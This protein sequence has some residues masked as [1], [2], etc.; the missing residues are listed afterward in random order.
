MGALVLTRKQQPVAY[1]AGQKQIVQLHK[2]MLYRELYL[3]L[4]GAPTLLAANNT[5]AKTKKGD[6]WACVQKIEIIVNSSDVIRSFSG[7]QLWQLNRMY[8]GCNPAVTPA[9]GDGA[10]A[11]PPF[12]ST[13]VIPFWSP[14][15][16]RPFD[17]AF[18]T[19]G[20]TDFRLEI[21]WG[22]PTDINADAAAFTTAPAIEIGSHEQDH[23]A[24]P[25]AHPRLLKR[26]VTQTLDVSGASG[27]FRFPLDVGPRY[28][29][30]L[31]NVTTAAGVDTAGLA[32]NFKLVSG[33][34][35]FVDVS[36]PMLYQANA[37]RSDIGFPQLPVV[38]TGIFS[39]APIRVSAAS[40]PR[41]WYNLDLVTDRHVGRVSD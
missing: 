34:T 12:D 15:V 31:I 11:N 36:E 21:T 26:V 29:G 37:L 8:Y 35:T 16:I 27:N 22:L 20:V 25:A 4:T 3:R 40:N 13:L 32:T 18:D 2:S 38:A 41:A 19:A 14:R 23:P 24:D 9:I 7:D 10:T 30:F 17:T 1:V 33:S 5:V 28:R 39:N 6:E